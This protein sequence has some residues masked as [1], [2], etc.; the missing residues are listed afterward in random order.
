MD[1][2]SDSVYRVLGSE[3]DLRGTGDTDVQE[4]GI[5]EGKGC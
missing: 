2:T 4:G 5:E 1:R 3:L